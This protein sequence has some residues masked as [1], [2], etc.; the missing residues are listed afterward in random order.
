MESG[1]QGD[2]GGP[3]ICKQADESYSLCGLVSWGVGCARPNLPGVYTDVAFYH[4]WIV[5]KLNSETVEP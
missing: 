2:S 3:L 1:S 4:D 5:E